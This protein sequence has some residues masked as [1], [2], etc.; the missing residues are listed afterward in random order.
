V[1]V[2][3]AVSVRPDTGCLSSVAS[4]P[5]VVR[6]LA[7][8]VAFGP[9]MLAIVFGAKE[10]LFAAPDIEGLLFS[11]PEFVD[12]FLASSTEPFEGRD[13]WLELEAV[14]AFTPIAGRFPLAIAGGL[15][16]GLLR[17]LP[18]VGLV[19]VA[20]FVDGLVVGAVDVVGRFAAAVGRFGGM[21]FLRGDDGDV[22]TPAF[23][24][25]ESVVRAGLSS[26]E[27]ISSSFS[28][29]GGVSTDEPFSREVMT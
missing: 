13:T 15:A 21:P 29:A 7:D 10:T 23:N 16:G 28:S 18:G 2:G 9:A 14:A 25:E 24:F 17:A 6:L 3:L 11:T 26:P 1:R 19:V 20:A 5:I 8:G 27:R 22:L 12:A 4:P